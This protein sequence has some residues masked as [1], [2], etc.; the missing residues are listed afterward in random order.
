[1]SIS[2]KIEDCFVWKPN[3]VAISKLLHSI[4]IQHNSDTQRTSCLYLKYALRS[5]YVFHHK[6]TWPFGWSSRSQTRSF[7][8]C[9][10]SINFHIHL[11]PYSLHFQIEANQDD[12]TPHERL[13]LS[14]SISSSLAATTAT[15]HISMETASQ[16]S[17]SVGYGS[18]GGDVSPRLQV[19][20][21]D[22]VVANVIFVEVIYGSRF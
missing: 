22:Y 16:C 1:M 21:W 5:Y 7:T 2:N 4:H 19:S 11:Y 10:N 18:E 9:L 8:Y 15:T 13:F 17:S 6:I 14:G 12:L 3:Y 20:A